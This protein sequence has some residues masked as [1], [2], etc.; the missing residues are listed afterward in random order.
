[1]AG[2]CGAAAKSS[3]WEVSFDGKP[4]QKRFANAGEARIYIGL[5]AKGRRATMKPVPRKAA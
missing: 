5:N 2:C 4:E 3:D 1:M